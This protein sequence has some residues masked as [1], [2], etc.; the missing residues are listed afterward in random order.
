V[1]EGVMLSWFLLAALSLAFVAVDVRTTPESTVMK[2]G[3]VLLTAYTGPIG[4]FLYVLGCREPLPGLHERYVAVRWRQVLGSTM[5]CVAGD[6]VGILVGAVLARQFHIE[7]FS[8]IALEYGLGFLFGWTVFQALFM[9][10]MTGSYAKSLK[11]TFIPEF[12]SMNILMAGM[13]PVAALFAR[14]F[15]TSRDPLLPEFWFR[16]SMALLAGFVVAFPMNW[17]LVARHLKHGMTTARPALGATQTSQSRKPATKSDHTEHS[18]ARGSPKKMT[19]NMPNQ[20]V[21]Q[22]AIF[23]MMILSIVVFAAGLMLAAWI[24]AMP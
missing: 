15:D 2:W 1:L 18:K 16:M 3:F 24:G 13:I 23:G 5:H 9:R 4:V 6:G 10:D 21:P 7:G 20:A 12:L 22:T 8:E 14:Y 11:T 17:W 19:S